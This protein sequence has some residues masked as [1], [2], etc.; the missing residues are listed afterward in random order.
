MPGGSH[1]AVEFYGAK[2]IA[3]Y[4]TYVVLVIGSEKVAKSREG[5]PYAVG[6]KG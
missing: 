6:C 5:G 4:L 3:S 2:R 1:K